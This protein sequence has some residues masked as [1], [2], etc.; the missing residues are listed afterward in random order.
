MT[1]DER[2][3]KDLTELYNYGEIVSAHDLSIK[4]F[5]SHDGFS[6]YGKPGHFA[7]NRNAK[8]VMVMLNPGKDV[9]TANNP[10]KTHSLLCDLDIK[11]NTLKDFI[12]TYKEASMNFGEKDFDKAINP[13]KYIE[14]YCLD[15]F[16]IK[17]AAFLKHWEGCEVKIL[18]PFPTKDDKDKRQIVKKDVLMDKLQLE[19]VP[20][21]SRTFEV[22]D[23]KLELLFP[24]VETLFDEIFR[25]DD[26]KYVI[27]CSDYF[28][29]LF[30]RYSKDDRYPGWIKIDQTETDPSILKNGVS[31]TPIR[32]YRN[33]KEK[34]PEDV[35][36]LKAV[37]AHTFPNQALPN[38]YDLMI[39]YG[40][41]CYKTFINSKI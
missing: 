17:Q 28:K 24:F 36:S 6:A 22:K 1:L 33:G 26:R 29:K 19:L 41:F 4:M 2:I 31:C 38:A 34:C 39:D 20:Y 37:I 11:T 13:N 35:P 8:T 12:R 25:K 3:E 9:A 10:I 18:D 32:I 16:D 27:F 5:G 7:G 30:E 15:N 40:E 23:E 14:K 21:A